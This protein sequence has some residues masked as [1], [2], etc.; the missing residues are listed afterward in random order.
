MIIGLSA[1]SLLPFNENYDNI[2]TA[3]FIGCF[4]FIVWFVITI[5][6]IGEFKFR[7]DL[8]QIFFLSGICAIPVATKM[9]TVLHPYIKAKEG[10]V[11]YGI[12][13]SVTAI[14]IALLS[15][16]VGLSLV[17]ASQIVEEKMYPWFEK[18]GL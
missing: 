17:K 7:F 14:I 2:D 11:I 12:S 13:L 18:I 8:K 4:L 10:G 3:H 1:V 16:I 9:F 15:L 5:L 6:A